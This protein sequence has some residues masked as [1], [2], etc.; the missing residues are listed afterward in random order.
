MVLDGTWAEVGTAA[1]LMTWY[2]R[3]EGDCVWG[4]GHIEDVPPAGSLDPRPDHVQ[5]LAGRMGSD[6]I[7]TGEILYLVQCPCGIT[8]YSALRMFVEFDDSGEILLREDREPG[9]SGPRCPDPG[10]FCP[11]PLV[12]K[13]AE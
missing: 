1:P 5:S 12:L 3:T 4:A 8:P 7:I 9:V 10:G 2:I 13:R 6:Y 11:A